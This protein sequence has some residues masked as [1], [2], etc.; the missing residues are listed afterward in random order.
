MIQ[1]LI[2]ELIAYISGE[3]KQKEI[4]AAKEAYFREAGGIYGEEDS[5]DMRIGT[6]LDWYIFDRMAGGKSVLEEYLETME[7]VARK[8]EFQKLRENRR[9]I[10]EIKKINKE[11]L[12]LR[13]LKDKK[14]YFA[15][16]ADFI[17]G[18]KK[19]NLIETRIFPFEREY[20][21]SPAFIFHPEKAKKYIIKSL[22]DGE[23]LNNLGQVIISLAN[24]SLKWERFRNYKVEDIYK[25]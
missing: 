13:D 11:G 7:D 8:E 14:K 17:E 1:D 24:K 25:D 18:L 10:F 22:R 15:R 23:F 2:N 3:E 12:Y 19:G 20:F 4:A 21:M 5:Y 6:F 9:S 16:T